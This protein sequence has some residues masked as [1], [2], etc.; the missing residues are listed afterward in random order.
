MAIYT[1]IQSINIP[2]KGV[3]KFIT[4]KSDAFDLGADS[5]Q[6]NWRILDHVELLSGPPFEGKELLNGNLLMANSDLQTWGADDNVAIDWVINELN[7]TK[8]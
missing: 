1:Q 7:L 8:K 3:G 6:L 5:V 4:I 2:T